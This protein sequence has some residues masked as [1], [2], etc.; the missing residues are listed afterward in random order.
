MEFHAS[1]I[2]AV[3]FAL[4]LAIIGFFWRLTTSKLIDT[5]FGKAMAFI[6]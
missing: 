3:Q 4:Y 1:F 5:P 2:G 6:Y